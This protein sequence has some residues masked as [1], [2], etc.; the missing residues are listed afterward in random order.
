LI[1]GITPCV[2][3][4]AYSQPGVSSSHSSRDRSAC[5]EHLPLTFRILVMEQLPLIE[6]FSVLLLPLA[7]IGSLML[8]SL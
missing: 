1:I 4:S 3:V 2:L 6:I 5:T 7:K 8:L